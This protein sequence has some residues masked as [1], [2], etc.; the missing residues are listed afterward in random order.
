MESYS[1]SVSGGTLASRASRAV[2]RG[3]AAAQPRPALAYVRRVDAPGSRDPTWY[4]R[5]RA[6]RGE[7]RLTTPQIMNFRAVCRASQF[8]IGWRPDPGALTL[9]AWRAMLDDAL[10]PL[11]GGPRRGGQQ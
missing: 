5:W 4:L 11:R 7:V 9:G 2:Y 8:Q 1:T 3:E 6:H 10:A